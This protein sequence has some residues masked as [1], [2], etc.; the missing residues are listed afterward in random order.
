M[1]LTDTHPRVRDLQ[2]DLLRAAGGSGRW[3]IMADLSETVR[4]LS[5]RA[6]ADRYPNATGPELGRIFVELHYGESVASL[7]DR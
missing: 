3:K 6:I 4:E 1:E 7:M 5:R 2:I